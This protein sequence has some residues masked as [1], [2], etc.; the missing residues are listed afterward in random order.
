MNVDVQKAGALMQSD[1]YT[2]ALPTLAGVKERIEAIIT[3]V[4]NLTTAQ[5]QRRRR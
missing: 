4:N 1:D 3:S 2:N 5:T